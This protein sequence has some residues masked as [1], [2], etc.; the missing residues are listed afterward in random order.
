[1]VLNKVK[2]EF[3]KLALD[4][5]SII[6]WICERHPY[7]LYSFLEGFIRKEYHP[8]GIELDLDKLYHEVIDLC[9]GKIEHE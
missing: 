4:D 8:K 2:Y 1:M 9:D 3:L 5:L 7:A 6:A